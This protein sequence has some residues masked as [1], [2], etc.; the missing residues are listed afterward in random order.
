MAGAP[1][2][3]SRL[4]FLWAWAWWIWA[5]VREIDAHAAHEDI[6]NWLVAFTVLTMVGAGWA[7]RRFQWPP[8]QWPVQ[9]GFALGPVLA[10]LTH[11][12]N[13]ATLERNGWLAW[14]LWLAGTLLVLALV[15]APRMRA[16][17]FAHVFFLGTLALV[18]G[19]EGEYLARV[20]LALGD[21]WRVTFAIVPCSRSRSGRSAS[22]RSRPRRSLPSSRSTGA[23][24]SRPH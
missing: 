1:I 2:G 16:L 18:L 5:G 14:L 17:A 12:Y 22:P 7:W 20:T 11:E 23:P 19:L 21:G 8:Y 3:F 4:L 10:L 9:I 6:G 13:G 24:G 15:R